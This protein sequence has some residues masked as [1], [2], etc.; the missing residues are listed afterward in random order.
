MLLEADR[1]GWAASGRNGGFCAASLTHGLA[2]GVE[3]FADEIDTL[4][5]L[6]RDNLDGIETAV[7]RWSIDCGFERTGELSVAT[8]GFQVA[9]LLAAAEQARGHGH[10]PIFLDREEVRAEVHSPTYLAGLWDRRGCALVNPARLA[11]GLR[12]ACASAGVRIYEHSPV[13]QLDSGARW[14]PR[15]DDPQDRAREGPFVG[16][17]PRDQRRPVVG[18]A[19]APLRRSRLRLRADDRGA[20]P[21]TAGLHRMGA[22]P[23]DRRQ[24]QPVPLLPAEPDDR[25][26]FGG[27]DA[28]YHFG[29]GLRPALEQ[30]RATFVKLAELFVETFP[31]LEDVRFT[32]SWA[33]A[34]D[35]CSRF[36]AFFDRS[37]EGRVVSAS[38]YTGLGVGASRFGAQVMLDLLSGE[39]T[40][41]T[42]L[43]FVRS[44]PLPFPP[45]PI[46][47]PASDS[48]GGRWRRPTATA[49]G[50]IS[51]FGHWTEW[52]WA[53][54]PDGRGREPVSDRPDQRREA[55]CS[56]GHRLD[57]PVPEGP[58][59]LV[60]ERP[61]EGAEPEVEGQAPR[62]F[63]E[64]GAPVH[65]EQA[66]PSP[67]VRPRPVRKVPSTDPAGTPSGTTKAR[68]MS[69][70]G[71]RLRGRD[72]SG[73]RGT[74]P[75]SSSRPRSRSSHPTRRGR[76]SGPKS[77]KL[78]T[79]VGSSSPTTP[80]STGSRDPA[81]PDPDRPVLTTAEVR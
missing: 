38:G 4:E 21:G 28:V 73:R 55:P 51:G 46:R 8:E 13:D 27:Y 24:R 11:W 74:R 61:V 29:N 7:A 33:G 64:R 43:R 16:G 75:G 63:R 70:E 66:P 1:C 36:C 60:G 57:A 71:N 3:R 22:P 41:L 58:D 26:L 67:T 47:S 81:V 42:T 14:V 31:Q 40:E 9:A 18:A 39:D 34:I 30:R 53:S 48:P 77:P 80:S 44:K 37:H 69:E 20:E 56:C 79:T 65:V 52:A 68:S 72:C 10:A 23:G 19:P 62:T 32:H 45:E 54:T 50:A 25:V 59:L 76:P 2:N 49:A 15:G 17:G 6:G 35:T 12:R 5:R 78:A